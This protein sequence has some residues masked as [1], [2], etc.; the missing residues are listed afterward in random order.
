M[1][2]CNNGRMRTIA[3]S[4][5]STG[6]IT[7]DLPK[8]DYVR[9]KMLAAAGGRG[10][11]MTS[12]VRRLVGEYLDSSEDAADLALVAERA[13]NSA[14]SLSRTDVEESLAARG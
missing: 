1:K 6:R 4:P 5:D 3:A 10:S 9:L 8:E 2:S 7:V 14:E 12:I 13:Q 11:T